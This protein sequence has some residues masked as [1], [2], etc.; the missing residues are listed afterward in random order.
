MT[1]PFFKTFSKH[2]P[3][4]LG[5]VLNTSLIF[6]LLGLCHKECFVH[7]LIK[8]GLMASGQHI[9]EIDILKKFSNFHMQMYWSSIQLK[10]DRCS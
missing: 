10:P 3:T 5:V 4:F 8:I 2:L 9:L 7:I 1:Y 6:L